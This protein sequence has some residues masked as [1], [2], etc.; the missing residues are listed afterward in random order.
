MLDTIYIFNSIELKLVVGKYVERQVLIYR[1]RK[2]RAC[3][4]AG[5][6]EDKWNQTKRERRRGRWNVANGVAAVE[7]KLLLPPTSAGKSPSNAA[8][9]DGKRY[10]QSVAFPE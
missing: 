7:G 6:A 5:T 3:K 10:S 8:R 1:E 2:H 9:N 4:I